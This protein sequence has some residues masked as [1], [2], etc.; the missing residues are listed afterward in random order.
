MKR[1]ALCPIVDIWLA[2]LS[3]LEMHGQLYTVT[4]L[5]HDF[6][7]N[8]QLSD[9]NVVFSDARSGQLHLQLFGGYVVFSNARRSGH[10]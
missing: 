8:L 4:S 1:I 2:Y 3:L 6:Q 7:P 10:D 9:E 5:Y